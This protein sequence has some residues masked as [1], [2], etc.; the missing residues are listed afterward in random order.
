MNTNTTSLSSLK[1]ARKAARA[2]L[3]EANKQS[4]DAA[5]TYNAA[6]SGAYS[7]CTGNPGAFTT[8]DRAAARARVAQLGAEF[9]AATAAAEQAQA[10]HRA[11]CTAYDRAEYEDQQQ[12][13]R[14]VMRAR[15]DVALT[16]AGRYT[17]A[18]VPD[19]AAA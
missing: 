16:P 4:S 10:R 14:E 18:R 9:H 13:R 7:V 8:E 19:H 5:R 12:S 6:A 1:L 2:A 17:L 3:V 15:Y 11:A